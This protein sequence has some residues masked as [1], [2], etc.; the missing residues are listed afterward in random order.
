MLAPSSE[1]RRSLLPLLACTCDLQ[2]P[3]CLPACISA[4]NARFKHTPGRTRFSFLF[5]P[6]T[7]DISFSLTLHLDLS[8][9]RSQS[10]MADIQL[11][12]DDAA[13]V[14]II[15]NITHLRSRDVPNTL[16]LESLLETAELA[17][18]YDVGE[19]IKPSTQIWI[20]QLQGSADDET[21]L[22]LLRAA[23]QLQHAE[24]FASLGQQIV[25]QNTVIRRTE[26]RSTA[27]LEA[28]DVV[29]GKTETVPRSF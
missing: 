5:L 18:K 1:K 23:Y 27:S 24:C 22:K 4:A 16:S 21:R 15:C 28:L 3:A 17:D 9:A 19:P 8:A 2:T 12:D 29:F 11:P 20:V 6:P 10:K 13:S 14:G 26:D 25:M 7:S